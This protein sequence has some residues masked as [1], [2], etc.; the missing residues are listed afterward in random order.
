MTHDDLTPDRMHVHD[1]DITALILDYVRNRLS[2]EETPLD[3]P[4]DREQLGELL[5][6][7]LGAEG[8]DPADVMALYSEHLSRA[9]ISADSPRFFAFI[10]AAPTKASLL[11]DMVVSSASLQGISW[12]EAA[13]A[14]AAENQVLRLLADLAGLPER[15]GGCF[16]SGGSAGNL[17]ALAVA[18]DTARRSQSLGRAR[19]RVAVGD[20][21]HSSITHTLSILDM[22]PLLVPTAD[23]RLTGEALGRALVA[24]AEA[25]N[26]PATV[27]A[28]VATAGTTNA[29]IIDELSSV[30]AVAK[31]RG[32]WLHVDAAYG[33][34]GLF[35][36]GV[37]S[38]YE[39]I[40]HADSIVMDPHKWLFAPFD[41]AALLYR[42]PGLARVVHTQDASYLDAI[43]DEP[44]DWNP[45]DYA[46]HL[47]RR[48]R[49]LP[50]WF[51]LA[52]NGTDGYRD[53]IAHGI[54]L[55][56]STADLIAAAP[57]LE[58]IR[59]PELSV[60]LFRRIGWTTADYRHWCEGLLA[61]QIA[62]VTPSSWEGETVG[63]LVFLHPQTTIKMVEDV[64]ERTAP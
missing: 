8:N 32:L 56:R 33:G 55:A 61:D 12:L 45:T 27:V 47:T 41:C 44:T 15:A 53:A 50:L 19:L 52:V 20:Q 46:Y 21:A 22:D 49:G 1:P 17:S 26:D 10:P 58:L 62:F 23:H 2:M 34:A 40:E 18:R 48:A 3:F 14:V 9:V 57:Q 24:D 64:L 6:G 63:R 13:G 43:H 11:F 42:E 35:V 25:G 30:A 7:L 31:A 5:S 37:R 36:P 39:G 54:E 59:E 60:V 38:R 28:V 51:S 4:G 16:V 29:G